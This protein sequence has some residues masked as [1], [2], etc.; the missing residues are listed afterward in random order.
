MTPMHG[1]REGL[2]GSARRRG[3]RWGRSFA[4]AAGAACWLALVQ[5]GCATTGAE[6]RTTTD[7]TV[8]SPARI[9][10]LEPVAGPGAVLQPRTLPEGVV[11]LDEA[12][13]LAAVRPAVRDALAASAPDLAFET[14]AGFS[15]AEGADLAARASRQYLDART[16]EPTLGRELAAA[17]GADAVLVVAILKVGPEIEGD[18][19]GIQRSVNTTVGTTSVGISSSASPVVVYLNAQIRCALL[20]GDD[21]R[22]AWDAGVRERRKRGLVR[23]WTLG[24]VIAEAATALGGAFPWRR[25]GSPAGGS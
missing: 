17:T 9:A 19:Q 2:D 20:R 3:G 6:V 4:A 16:V 5:Q 15:R 8:W 14:P 12:A 11:A 22:I 24:E 7:P 1:R 21:G 23:A 13:T 18:V 10:I 25:A